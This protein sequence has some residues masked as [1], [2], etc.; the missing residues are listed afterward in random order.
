MLKTFEQTPMELNREEIKRY[1]RHL[2]MPEFGKQAQ[3]K[4]KSSSVLIVGAGGLGC[5]L[6]IYLAAAGVGHIGIVDFDVVDISNLQR[7]IIYSTDDV[8]RPKAETA[9]QKIEAMN[10]NIK[11]SVYNISFRSENAKEI[12]QEYQLII[13]GTDNFPTRYLVSDLCVQTGKKNVFGSIFRFDGQLTVFGGKNGPCYR[14]LYP[15]PPPAG[16]VPS[17]AEGGVLGILPGIVGVMQATE[18]IKILTGTGQSMVGRLLLFDALKMKFKEVRIKKNPECPVCSE[19]PTIKELIDYE[20]FCGVKVIEEENKDS[21]KEEEI[22]VGELK[23]LFDASSEKPYLLDVRNP[24]EWDICY[25][26]G[27][28][29]IPLPELSSRL[30][31]IPQERRIITIC[32][33]GRRSLTALDIL[34]GIGLKN[35]QSL[36][37]GVEEWAL[38][39]DPQMAR[40]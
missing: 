30:N 1:S 33:S 9:K 7:Q 28:F 29:L 24:Q 35:V 19:N 11:V 16:M 36:R 10:P 39:I 23:R 13:D 26:E 25:I 40:Y 5:P 32:H 21:A 38:K 15:D 2:I 14:C 17:C 37:G 4:L 31:E 22:S 27:S 20:E 6:S 3:E 18:T 34:K 8:G 12:A